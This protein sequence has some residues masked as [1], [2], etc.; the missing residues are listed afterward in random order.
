MPYTGTRGCFMQVRLRLGPFRGNDLMLLRRRNLH[1]GPTWTHQPVAMLS[2][3]RSFSTS[4]KTLKK[5]AKVAKEQITGDESPTD[6][7]ELEAAIQKAHERLK[8]DLS[9]LRSGG[10]FNPEVVENLRVHVVK[11]S[12]ETVRLSDVAQ[13]VPR[14]RILNLMIGEKE[15]WTYRSRPCP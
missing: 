1:I 6:F 7:T 13:V 9:K 3:Q 10:R 14:G 5:A 11:G 4:P 8:E 2:T 12:K 15:V